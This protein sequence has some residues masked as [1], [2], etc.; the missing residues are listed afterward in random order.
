MSERGSVEP[1]MAIISSLI[2]GLAFPLRIG[3]YMAVGWSTDPPRLP[4]PQLGPTSTP[5]LQCMSTCKVTQLGSVLAI[6]QWSVSSYGVEDTSR[7]SLTWHWS[8]PYSTSPYNRRLTL[9][10]QTHATRSSP[11]S[12]KM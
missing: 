4:N 3:S 8:S 12:L 5:P 6:D 9:L 10:T 1:P 2:S 7:G 11:L